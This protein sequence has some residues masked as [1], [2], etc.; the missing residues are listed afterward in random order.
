MKKLSLKFKRALKQSFGIL[1]ITIL[2]FYLVDYGFGIIFPDPS[3]PYDAAR[4][5][6][7]HPS[8]I[9]EPYFSE[10]FLIE[11]FTIPGGWLTHEDSVLFFPLEFHGRYF[12]VD[13]VNG[14]QYRRTLNPDPGPGENSIKVLMLGGS[15]VFNSEVPDELTISSQLSE[16]LNSSSINKEYLILNAGVTS[17]NTRQE[18]ARLEFE[19]KNGTNPD[20]VIAFHG[21]N[22]I[23]Q[24][25]YFNDPSGVMFSGENRPKTNKYLR[26]AKEFLR[27]NIYKRLKR[28]QITSGKR[29]IPPHMQDDEIVARRAGET[30]QVYLENVRKMFSLSQEYGF[31]LYIFLQPNL[32]SGS[33]IHQTE[34]IKLGY[35]WS[36]EKYPYVSKA[37]QTGHPYLQ[38]AISDLKKQG[39]LAFDASD[40]FNN[41]RKDIFLDFCHVNSI[42]NSIIAQHLSQVITKPD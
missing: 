39:L 12:N 8:Y 15:T 5:R 19:L 17:V 11:S 3:R 27:G 23:L 29:S 6:L 1:F 28:K 16:I 21:V 22:E 9:N 26:Q 36:K 20:I 33:Y 14:I 31:K 10:E 2:C 7:T 30:E 42:G 24:G 38:N 40:I 34:D 25:I 32:Y 13:T 37:F 18:L 41:K 35:E 4:E